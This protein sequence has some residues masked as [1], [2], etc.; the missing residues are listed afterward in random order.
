MVEIS[1]IM[2][3]ETA[4]A[5]QITDDEKLLHWVPKSQVEWHPPE[6]GKRVGVMVMPEWL[7]KEKGFI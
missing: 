4:K 3:A 2:K 5:Y 1:C 7:A 6:P